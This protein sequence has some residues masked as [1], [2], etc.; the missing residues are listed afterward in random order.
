MNFRTALA[1][2]ACLLGI[3]LSTTQAAVIV[4]DN[5]EGYSSQANFQGT[6]APIGTV[7]PTSA[8]WSTEQASSPT[9]S[10]KISGESTVNGEE[11]NRRSFTDTTALTPGAKVV[12]SYDFY[13]SNGGGAP[14]RQ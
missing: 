6:W 13:D 10:V 9:H 12:W 8:T 5:F 7:A 11:R 1:S 14:Y 4:N 2:A 3:G